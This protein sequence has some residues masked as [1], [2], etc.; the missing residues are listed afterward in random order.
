MMNLNK[1]IIAL[2]LG[3][4]MMASVFAQGTAFTYRGQLYSGTDLA[5]GSYNF[6]FSLY[7][8]NTGGG[9]IGTPV[10]NNPVSVS[11]GLFIV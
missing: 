3:N 2:S 5:N 4:L 9:V 11:N 7:N 10:T 1:L 8:T 6:A